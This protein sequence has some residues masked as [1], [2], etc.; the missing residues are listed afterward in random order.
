MSP[1]TIKFSS[2]FAEATEMS[3]LVASKITS[4]L[5]KVM[6]WRAGAG[7]EAANKAAKLNAKYGG[8][9]IYDRRTRGGKYYHAEY[10]KFINAK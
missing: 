9:A 2:K 10:T 6:L 4:G 1:H 8:R 3:G 7:I 5:D